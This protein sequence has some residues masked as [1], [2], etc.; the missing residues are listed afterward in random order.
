MVRTDPRANKVRQ[1]D[2]TSSMAQR[3]VQ[4]VRYGDAKLAGPGFFP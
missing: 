2:E 1:D 4:I 3:K